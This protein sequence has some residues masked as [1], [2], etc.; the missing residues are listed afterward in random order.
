MIVSRI[1]PH[2]EQTRLWPDDREIRSPAALRPYVGRF[3]EEVARVAFGLERH[4]TDS[5]ADICPDLSDGKRKFCEV[6]SVA[7]GNGAIIYR[8]R[9]LHD[10]QLVKQTRGTLTYAFFVHVAQLGG[11]KTL[12]ELQIE[13]AFNLHRVV[14]MPLAWVEAQCAVLPLRTLNYRKGGKA[15]AGWRLPQRYL[16]GAALGQARFIPGLQAFG[17]GMPG[18]PFLGAP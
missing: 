4:V 10:R 8:N 2:Q 14:C 9:L 7:M 16:D 1:T 5:R 11:V 6:K 3:Y 17:V 12:R 15:M 18:V 13:L